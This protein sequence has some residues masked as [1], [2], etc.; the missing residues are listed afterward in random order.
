MLQ[1]LELEVYFFVQEWCVIDVKTVKYNSIMFVFTFKSW[2]LWFFY[3]LFD[4]FSFLWK[5]TE[6]RI[7]IN[8]QVLLQWYLPSVVTR[9]HN[10]NLQFG[11]WSVLKLNRILVPGLQE[12]QTTTSG[13]IQEFAPGTLVESRALPKQGGADSSEGSMSCKKQCY[14]MQSHFVKFV[15]GSKAY[16]D[17]EC[18]ACNY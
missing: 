5:K 2:F 10:F 11:F 1:T 16:T 4:C 9:C 17:C 3:L 12:R 7:L 6:Y 18:L 8:D 13:R 14:V 15:L